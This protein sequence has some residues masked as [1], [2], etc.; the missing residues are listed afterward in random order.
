MPRLSFGFTLP[1][2]IPP[3]ATVG[4]ARL[5][6][7]LGFDRLWLPD[8]LLHVDLEAGAPDPWSLIAAIAPVTR[9]ITLGTAVSD[10]HRLH[11]AVLA[12]RLATCDKLSRGRVILGLGS[13]EAMNLEPFGIPWD[14]RL[15]RLREAIHIM[16][17][18]L[19][20]DEPL[21]FEGQ[22]YR[23]RRAVLTIRPYRRRHIPFYL[24]ALGP[25]TQKLC[26]E[27]ADGWFPVVVPPRF[28]G[29]YFQPVARAARAAGRD[30]ESLE[31]VAMVVLALVEDQAQVS[32]R[33]R[34]FALSLAWPPVLRQLHMEISGIPEDLAGTDYIT[35][36]PVDPESVRRYREHEKLI[37]TEVLRQFVVAGSLAD[38]KRGLGQYIEAGATHLDLL[39]ASPDPLGSTVTLASE[40]LPYFTGRRTTLAARALRLAVPLARRLGVAPSLPGSRHSLQ[41][42]A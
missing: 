34:Q 19:D 42:K 16:R 6:E 31:R 3:R 1:G 4:L 10:P 14:H 8:H 17:H 24:A 30:P 37:P 11:P 25:R 28:Y 23:L 27:V 39:N 29:Q 35:V 33:L 40:V 7:A 12:Q 32:R 41:D 2:D 9:R 22:F 13:G 38:I 20:S 26:G 5:I 18:L 36:N 21:T 15:G